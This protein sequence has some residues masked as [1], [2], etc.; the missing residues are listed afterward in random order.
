MPYYNTAEPTSSSK[1]TINSIV[2]DYGIRDFLLRK[3]LLPV[4]PFLSTTV[5]GSPKIGE[6]ILDTMVGV[7]NV[8]QPFGLP[9]E[10]EGILRMDIALLPN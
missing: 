3:N 1:N 6:P 5:N 8:V 7:G 10:T 9:L 4:Y 2:V